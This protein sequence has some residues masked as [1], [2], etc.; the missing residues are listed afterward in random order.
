[1]NKNAK[2][3]GKKLHPKK[4]S[5]TWRRKS[6]KACWKSWR[7]WRRPSSSAAKICWIKRKNRSVCWRRV[8]SEGIIYQTGNFFPDFHKT[9]WN[10][11]VSFRFFFGHSRELELRRKKEE[12]LRK[13]LLS[14]KSER[15]KMEE[16]FATLQ[17]VAAAKR[18]DVS[19]LKAEL[20][21]LKTDLRD[22]RQVYQYFSIFYLIL[23]HFRAQWST[24]TS[25]KN[26]MKIF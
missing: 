15:T 13:T 22:L 16:K 12:D 9:E 24:L 10:F 25:K 4:K 8:Q 20:G 7:D 5:W 2:S 17:E 19:R 26:F 1:M 18:L 23:F 11:F 3:Y 14:K 6:G 21:S